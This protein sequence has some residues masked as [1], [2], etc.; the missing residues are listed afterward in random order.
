MMHPRTYK[1]NRFVRIITFGWPIAITLAPFG[2]Y[3]IPKYFDNP[4][5]RN[6]ESIHWYQQCELWFL[7]FYLWYLFEWFIRLFTNW[8]MAY[9]SISFE[10]EAYDNDNDLEYLLRRDRFSW[11]KYVRRKVKIFSLRYGSGRKLIK[12]RKNMSYEAFRP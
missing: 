5:V 7:G 6:H 3:I 1:M 2:I 12:Q 11:L 9:M 10:R 4:Q 8:G